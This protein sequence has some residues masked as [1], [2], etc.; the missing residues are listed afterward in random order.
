[1]MEDRCELKSDYN[2]IKIFLTPRRVFFETKVHMR[3]LKGVK[4][5]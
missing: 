3:C 2:K 4:E 1:M 5:K